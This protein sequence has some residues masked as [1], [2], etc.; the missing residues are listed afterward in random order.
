MNSQN[1]ALMN[2]VIFSIQHFSLQIGLK[3][4]QFIFLKLYVPRIN[5]FVLLLG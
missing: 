4:L 5:L 3:H 1:L 2:L